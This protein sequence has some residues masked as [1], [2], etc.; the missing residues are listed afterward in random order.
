MYRY[1]PTPAVNTLYAYVDLGP[2]TYISSG[3]N[4]FEGLKMVG[5]AAAFGAAAVA[6]G[7]IAAGA[8]AGSAAYGTSQ[9]AADKA[10]DSMNGG[11]ANVGMEKT[12]TYK[13]A[14]DLKLYAD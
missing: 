9:F 2:E 4:A 7:G 10:A 3:G 11:L 1:P 5:G 14:A 8:I 12:T 13:D 6:T